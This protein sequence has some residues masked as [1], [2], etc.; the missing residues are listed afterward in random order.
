M[1]RTDLQNLAEERLADS[2]LLLANG[3]Y[4]TAYYIAGYAVEC[5][6]KAFY[7]QAD[8]SRGFLRQDFGA[9]NIYA[10]SKGT[11]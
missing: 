1:N 8:E 9:K 3:R 10:Q 5:G 6:L 2:E 7:S 4:G 11:C